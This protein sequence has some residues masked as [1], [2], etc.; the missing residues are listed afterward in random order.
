MRHRVL[1]HFDTDV[2]TPHLVR[3]RR[4]GAGAE[5]GVKDEV[6][7]VGGDMDYPF[8]KP[9]RFGSGKNLIIIEG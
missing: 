8:Q 3:H 7:G 5:E 9:F 4:R 2:A 1:T 6:A